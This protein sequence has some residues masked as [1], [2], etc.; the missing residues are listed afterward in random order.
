MPDVSPPEEPEDLNLTPRD[1]HALIDTGMQESGNC[2]IFWNRFTAVCIG[3]GS[4][5]KKWSKE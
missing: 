4:N 1:E 5:R 3:Y 2:N